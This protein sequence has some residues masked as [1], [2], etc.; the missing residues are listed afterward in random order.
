LT[1]LALDLVTGPVFCAAA[2]AQLIGRPL[3]YVVTAKGS[4]ATGDTWRTFRP[5]LLWLAV[6]AVAIAA[7]VFSGHDYPT[8]YLWA[9]LTVVICGGPMMHVAGHKLSERRE[10]RQ[11]SRLRDEP[12]DR[13]SA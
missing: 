10:W 9:L 7:G 13:A 2:A 1:G 3:V 5:H 6:S 4:A 11:V 8:L 12:Q